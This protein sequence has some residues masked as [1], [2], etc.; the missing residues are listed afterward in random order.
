MIKRELLQEIR[1]HLIQKEIT[2]IT[3]PR[4]AGKTTLMQLLQEELTR[5]GEKNLFLSL[6]FEEDR[7]FF[8]SQL[9]LLSKVQLEAGKS[10]AYVFI[11]EIQRKHDAGLFLKGLYDRNHPYKFIVSG[12]GSLELKE[13]IHESLAGRKR[14]FELNTCSFK[15]FIN[16][17]TTYH[18][19]D[20]FPEFIKIDKVRVSELFLEYL[21]F[22][23]YPKVILA[24]ELKT[25]R[26]VIDDIYRSYLERDI[27]AFLKIDKLESFSY[28][29]RVLSRQIG[30][31]INHQELS[32]T[33]N[34]SLPTVKDYLWY[35]EKTFIVQKITPYYTNARKEI[36]KSPVYYFCDIGLRNYTAGVFGHIHTLSEHGFLFQNLVYNI[37]Q[38]AIRF[39]GAK[40]H[41]WRTKDKAEVDFVIDYA[42]SPIPIEVKC[43]DMKRPET[44]RSFLSFIKKYSPQKAYVINL[45]LEAVQRVDK[46]DIYYMPFY[47]CM[48]MLGEITSRS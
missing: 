16:Y 1:E 48:D 14:I 37:L 32:N 23:G 15:E 34:I 3:G 6:D 2:L 25:K 43:R 5:N 30:N 10:K 41:F 17:R 40:I 46:T 21:N 35:A 28:M 33:L 36:T 9:S 31:L 20:R 12:S 45:S 22:G 11:D 24:D 19:E 27:A 18:Y 38:D 39:S 13:K 44:S 42:G 47:K 8:D 7:P 29:I 26:T 4:Q